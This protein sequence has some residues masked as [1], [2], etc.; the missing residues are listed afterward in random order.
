MVLNVLRRNA[1]GNG[2]RA[3]ET[4]AG[5]KVAALLA[6]VQFKLAL[7]AGAFRIETGSEDRSAIGATGARDGADHARGA[8]AE[9]IGPARAPSRGLFARSFFFF[10]VFRVAIAAVTVLTIHTSLRPPVFLHAS[11]D[12]HNCYKTPKQNGY[13]MRMVDR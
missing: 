7:W 1:I 9:L 13:A 6:A 8:R 4:H 10:F 2:L 11:T 3:L 5:I 12:C